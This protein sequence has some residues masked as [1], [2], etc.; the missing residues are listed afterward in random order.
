M[1]SRPNRSVQYGAL[2]YN[3]KSARDDAEKDA[4]G[5]GQQSEDI[6]ASI[7]QELDCIKASKP[8]MAERPFTTVRPQVA[9]LFFVKTRPPVE[10]VELVRRI[11]EDAKAVS[12]PTGWKARYLN[13]LNPVSLLG[14]ATESGVEKVAR[15]VLQPWF[16]LR[17]EGEKAEDNANQKPSSGE[18]SSEKQGPA[19]SAR[20]PR[21][22]LLLLALTHYSLV[23]H[24][25]QL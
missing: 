3:I 20:P 19:Y 4:D 11:C 1:H 23:R 15:Q 16:E 5:E 13:R 24:P 9:C 7:Q 25:I 6:E 18:Q 17:S 12:G 21:P 14:K 8:A 10:P 22:I 2:L